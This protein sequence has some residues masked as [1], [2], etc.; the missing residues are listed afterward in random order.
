[1]IDHIINSIVAL[2]PNVQVP[3]LILMAVFT[4]IAGFRF[5]TFRWIKAATYLVYVFIVAFVLVRFG[6]PLSVWLDGAF[7][8]HGSVSQ[9]PQDD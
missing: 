9:T 1:V 6:Q 7:Q 8:P 3:G 2:P 4:L 5:I